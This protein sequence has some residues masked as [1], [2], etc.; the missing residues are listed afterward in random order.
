MTYNDSDLWYF[1]ALGPYLALAKQDRALKLLRQKARDLVE[2]RKVIPQFPNIQIEELEFWYRTLRGIGA[3][4]VQS[5]EAMVTRCSWRGVV[6]GGWLALMNPRPEFA[7]VLAAIPSNEHGNE[8]AAR[9]ALAE[10]E[11]RS[12]A[13]EYEEMRRLAQLCRHCLATVPVVHMPLRVVPLEAEREMWELER[14]R[15]HEAYRRGGVDVA[16]QHIRMSR[17]AEWIM[18]YPQWYR[19][20]Q[21][22]PSR[23]EYIDGFTKSKFSK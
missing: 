23:R 6:W 8:W 13:G 2:F 1:I 10:I 3:L 15:I 11:G 18:P 22:I 16:R 9:C 17:Y 5:L 20:R 12:I 4:D 19:K 14:I 21:G 7:A